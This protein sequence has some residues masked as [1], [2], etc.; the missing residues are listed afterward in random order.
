M[1]WC[2]Q[3]RASDRSCFDP[4]FPTKD[5]QLKQE[6]QTSIQTLVLHWIDKLKL[7][8]H[9]KERK[10]VVISSDWLMCMVK[11]RPEDLPVRI[12]KVQGETERASS[13]LGSIN[14]KKTGSVNCSP[15]WRWIVVDICRPWIVLVH[16]TP[17]DSQQQKDPFCLRNKVKLR[18]NPEE[19]RDSLYRDWV[20]NQSARKTLFTGLVNTNLNYCLMSCAPAICGHI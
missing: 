9:A 13:T 18:K 1:P 12:S 6:T 19:S 4:V 10:Q 7:I 17:V 11:G 14:V 2:Q 3:C 8:K 16:T 20:A 5:Q 15:K